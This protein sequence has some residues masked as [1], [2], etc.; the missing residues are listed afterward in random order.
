MPT[1]T[2]PLSPSTG[3]RGREKRGGEGERGKEVARDK[4]REQETKEKALQ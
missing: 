3:N 4:Q 2:L 1:A